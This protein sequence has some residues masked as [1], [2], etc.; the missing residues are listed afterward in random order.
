[1]KVTILDKDENSLSEDLK[2]RIHVDTAGYPFVY[3]KKK[4]FRIHR[5][6]MGCH[7][8]DGKV[9]DHIN[10]NKL[11]NR[12]CN[13]R[14]CT[15][16]ENTLNRKMSRHNKLGVKGVSYDTW[17][18]RFVAKVRIKGKVYR[19]RFKTLEEARIEYIKMANKY[20]GEFAR[21]S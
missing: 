9:V 15:Q 20:H 6:I 13:L 19:K 17:N 8:G 1:M 14:I 18:S 7:K 5:I 2:N 10:S 4:P 11:D 21:T 16:A 12:K 3:I